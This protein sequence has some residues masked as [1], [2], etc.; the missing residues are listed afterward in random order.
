MPGNEGSDA[1]EKQRVR[2]EPAI[3]GR[4][5]LLR[6]LSSRNCRL[7]RIVPLPAQDADAEPRMSC[8]ST[9]L[10]FP[11][12]LLRE[13]EVRHIQVTTPL[14]APHRSQLTVKT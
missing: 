7:W 1:W 2:A 10:D 3:I 6:A 4:A 8:I 11:F 14:K 5:V 13:D 12:P 9:S